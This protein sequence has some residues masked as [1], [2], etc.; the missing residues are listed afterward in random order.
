MKINDCDIILYACIFI[1]VLIHYVA[2]ICYTYY[3]VKNDNIA[4]KIIRL[5]LPLI[6]VLVSSYLLLKLFQ[7]LFIISLGNQSC[8]MFI[9]I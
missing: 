9:N 4:N 2:H 7:R 6:D 3:R 8:K 5:L 1:T